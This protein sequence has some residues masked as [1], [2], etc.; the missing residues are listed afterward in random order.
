[1]QRNRPEEPE[2]PHGRTQPAGGQAALRVALFSLLFAVVW[3]F[4]LWYEVFENTADT[5][6][7]TCAAIIMGAAQAAIAAAVL[8]MLMVQGV[9]AVRVMAKGLV[10]L[11]P[12][13]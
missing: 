9:K 3:G 2:H 6:P 10:R 12:G 11:W 5:L 4:L 8:T 13:S 1:M 7:D